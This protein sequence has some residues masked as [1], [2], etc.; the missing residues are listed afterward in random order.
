MFYQI[1]TIDVDSKGISMMNAAHL[2]LLF[3]VFSTVSVLVHTFDPF[4]TTVVVGVGAT[5]GRTIWNYFHESCDS[6]WIAYN[7]TGENVQHSNMYR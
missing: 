2:F 3:Y 7:A 1:N 5:L 4:T 6:K